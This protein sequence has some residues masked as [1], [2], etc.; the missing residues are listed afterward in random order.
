M[1]K[2]FKIL[3]FIGPKLLVLIFV[4][5]TLIFIHSTG[6]FY[7]EN[8]QIKNH[9][10]DKLSPFPGNSNDNIHVFV[11]LSDVHISKVYKERKSELIKF[12]SEV[13][14]QIQ[15]DVIIVSGD[16]TDDLIKGYSHSGPIEEE[17]KDYRE[18]IN[19]CKKYVSHKTAWLDI[20]G[21]HDTLNIGYIND[22]FFKKYS[23]SGI[24]NHFGSYVHYWN[25]NSNN[26][27]RFVAMDL[28]VSPGLKIPYNFMGEYTNKVKLQVESLLKERKSESFNHT[29]MFGH[30]PSSAVM[31]RNSFLEILKESSLY[32][33][34]HLHSVMHLFQNMYAKQENGNLELELTDWK[35]FR[36]YRV[37]AVDHDLVSFADLRY[38]FD[39]VSL[40]ITNPKNSQT[41]INGYEP[42]G[43][44]KRSTHIRILLY[45]DNNQN[46]VKIFIDNNFLGLATQ[47]NEN[48]NLYTCQWDP[49]KYSKL[50][51][52]R[53]DV[54]DHNNDITFCKPFSIICR[55]VIKS[56]SKKHLIKSVKQHFSTDGTIE[57]FGFIQRF[58]IYNHIIGQSVKLLLAFIFFI[59]IAI[60]YYRYAAVSERDITI[61]KNTKFFTRPFWLFCR[62]HTVYFIVPHILYFYIGPWA[63]VEV[64]QDK[65][66]FI[67]MYGVY[68]D[69]KLISTAITFGLSTV[70]VI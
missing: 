40:I 10:R 70:H 28:S 6:I 22:A 21:N 13:L 65:Y 4:I 31:Q 57:S 33:C 63:Y 41:I 43:R 69:K 18:A 20:R 61:T 68:V 35:K 5:F 26:S 56:N 27:Y 45:S 59:L 34:G 12:C 38:R 42:I 49:C 8:V 24:N 39:N 37:V 19:E 47:N 15:P 66:G 25:P 50:H 23:E 60:I 64:Y 1:N 58:M 36:R 9:K 51:V 62:S 7:R 11:Q 3:N 29:F 16:L 52:I 67:F 30:Y 53:V 55:Y 48:K 14:A 44:I 54:Y 32:M 17:W 2:F 46:M